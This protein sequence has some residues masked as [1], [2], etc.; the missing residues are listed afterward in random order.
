MKINFKYLD[1][2][3]ILGDVALNVSPVFVVNKYWFESNKFRIIANQGG[4]RSGK[5]YSIIQLLCLIAA[6][7]PNLEISIVSKT[8]P[9]IKRGA[10]R[11]F[12]KIMTSSGSYIDKNFNKTDLIYKF[13]SGSYIEFFSAEN[14]DK[15]R[16]PGRDILYVNECNNLFHEEFREL[17]IRTRD[18]VIIDYNPI[19]EYHWIYD[20]ILTRNDCKFI[21]TTYL[22]N[23][24]YLPQEQI[25]EIERLK[26]Q[27]PVYWQIYGLGE[28]A[29]AANL[30]YNNFAIGD[31]FES[32]DNI[33]GLDFGFNNPTALI[34]LNVEDSNCSVQQL[35]YDRGLT[36]R[37]L[38]EQLNILIPNKSDFIYAD[39]AEPQRIQEILE[40]GFNIHPADKAV[41][42]G[43]DY[44]KNFKF[45]IDRNSPDLLK[46]FR[47]YKWR[48]DKN[49]MIL[50]DPVK[51]NDHLMDALRYALFTYGQIYLTSFKTILPM[52]F[53][54]KRYSIKS[55]KSSIFSSYR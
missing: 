14:A 52:K 23:Y 8:L 45:I 50:E 47:S 53:T 39:K 12:I 40:A 46:E 44:C 25:D 49:G 28:K 33:Y 48:E 13:N 37:D 18:K 6:N 35:I 34:K 29:R 41:S 30:I 9:H 27:D 20:Q 17:L 31:T 32:G 2:E 11:D 22:D 42:S 16:G 21:Q 10:L 7:T 36:N 43:I 15:L 1:D 51:F 55:N 5:T 19:D 26:E 4:T 38:I 3:P 24:D 54:N